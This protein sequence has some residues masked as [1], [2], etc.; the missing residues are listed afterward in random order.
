MNPIDIT[1]PCYEV[2][3]NATEGW[4]IRLRSTTPGKG[5]SYI[6]LVTKEESLKG[7]FKTGKAYKLVITEA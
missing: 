1:L 2:A 7:H 6:T 5:F 3:E 4:I